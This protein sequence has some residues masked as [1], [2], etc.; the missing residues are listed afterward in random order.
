MDFKEKREKMFRIGSYVMYGKQNSYYCICAQAKRQY[1]R[2]YR[3]QE[4][5][6]A[7]PLT[8]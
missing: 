6:Y 8:G 3:G 7:Y 1:G 4:N 2:R 5:R